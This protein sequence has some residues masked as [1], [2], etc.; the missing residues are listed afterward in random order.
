M[1][2]SKFDV[3]FSLKPHVE[4][5]ASELAEGA[6]VV[7]HNTSAT[8]TTPAPWSTTTSRTAATTSPSTWTTTPAPTPATIT[9]TVDLETITRSVPEVIKKIGDA[10]GQLNTFARSVSPVQG[11]TNSSPVNNTGTD[12]CPVPHVEV[13]FVIN[14]SI[15]IPV[16]VQ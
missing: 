4:W 9:S 5:S 15:S 13:K 1:E 11:V 8:T 12:C 16:L 14:R 3:A 10:A 7:G 2:Y 6:F